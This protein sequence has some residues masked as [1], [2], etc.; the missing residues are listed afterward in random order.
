MRNDRTPHQLSGEAASQLARQVRYLERLPR[1]RQ[2]H[3]RRSINRGGGSSSPT[4][5]KIR[6]ALSQALAGQASVDNCAVV[7]DW[8]S[9]AGATSVTVFNEDGWSADAAALGLAEWCPA[10][11]KWVITLLPCATGNS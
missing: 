9:N 1:N 6:F 2:P 8:Y 10:E 5:K 3:R 7:I 11:G 4:V